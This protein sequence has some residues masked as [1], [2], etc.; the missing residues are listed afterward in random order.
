VRERDDRYTLLEGMIEMNEG[1]FTIAASEN[2]HK[3]QKS[4]RGWIIV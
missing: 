1:Y 4:G 3:T 2:T